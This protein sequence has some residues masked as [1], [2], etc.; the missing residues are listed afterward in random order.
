MTTNWI[1]PNHIIQFAEIGAEEVDVAWDN[2]SEF[3]QIITKDRRS[4]PTTGQLVHIARSPKND[5]KNKTYYLR[6]TDFKFDQLPN[7]ISGI[8]VRINVQR[9][10]RAMDDTIQLC[11]DGKE[12]GENQADTELLLEKIYGSST[13]LWGLETFAKQDVENLTFGVS[14]RYKAHPNWPHSS[15]VLIDSVEMRI[16]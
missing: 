16:H 11:L 1:S 5:I 2:S 8:E 14:L 13:S 4:L 7:I 12:L 10:G 3:K 9:F 15:A 6:C